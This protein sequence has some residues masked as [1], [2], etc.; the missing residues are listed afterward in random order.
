MLCTGRTSSLSIHDEDWEHLSNTG[1]LLK[2]VDAGKGNCDKQ[3]DELFKK[4]DKDKSGVL[5]GK[6]YETFLDE[7]TKYM[8]ADLKKAGHDYDDPTIRAWVKQWI[9]RNG[10]GKITLNEL[11]AN[12]KAVLDAGEH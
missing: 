11:R 7:A 3:I 4:L 9:D 8:L 6:E 2:A 12:L 10:D 1:K 5:E